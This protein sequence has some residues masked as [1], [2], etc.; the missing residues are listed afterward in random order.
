MVSESTG[1]SIL[2]EL[3]MALGMGIC[4]AA[5]FKLMPQ[6]VS[7]AVG[8][9]AGWIGGLGAF[10]GFAIPPILGFFVRNLGPKGYAAGFVVY[11]VL[12]LASLGIAIGLRRMNAAQAKVEVARSAPS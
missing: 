12:A 1:L 8:G 2:A 5:V 7:E 3:L 6:Y 10:G 4:N 11:V 9:A